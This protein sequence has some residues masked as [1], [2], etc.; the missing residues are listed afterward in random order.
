MEYADIL[1]STLICFVPGIVGEDQYQ[2]PLCELNK[3][4]KSLPCRWTTMGTYFEKIC[5]L[6]TTN[7]FLGPI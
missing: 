3:E 1:E 7:Y 2:F 5:M 6:I 4:A